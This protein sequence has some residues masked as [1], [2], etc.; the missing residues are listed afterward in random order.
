MKKDRTWDIT[1]L[2]LSVIMLLLMMCIRSGRFVSSDTY[3]H[4]NRLL[5]MLDCFKDGKYPWFYYNDFQGVG[6]STPFFYGQ[7]TLLPFSIFLPLGVIGF[8]YAYSFICYI[9]IWLGVQ[10]FTKR[11]SDKYAQIAFV[12]ILSQFAVER[13]F[14]NQSLQAFKIGFGIG[15]F[16]L[17]YCVDIFRDRK[18]FIKPALLFCLIFDTSLNAAVVMFIACCVL[19]IVYF[20]SRMIRQYFRFAVLC[21]LLCSYFIVNILYHSDVL[22]RTKNIA[23]AIAT[24]NYSDDLIVGFSGFGQPGIRLLGVLPFLWS[25]KCLLS[26]KL[27]KREV[28]GL[29][30]CAVCVIASY[31]PIFI[32]SGLYILF[33]VPVR[34]LGIIVLVYLIIAFRHEDLRWF[35]VMSCI[36]TAVTSCIYVSRSGLLEEEDI[37]TLGSVAMG[38]YLHESFDWEVFDSM[39]QANGKAFTE[40]RG[41][42]VMQSDGEEELY[43][44]KLYYRGY[45]ASGSDRT[46]D[47][48]MG[49]SQFIY[50]EPD[51]YVGEIR[52]EYCHPIWLKTLGIFCLGLW[53]IIAGVSYHNRGY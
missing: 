22:T 18:G 8:G 20:D 51:G 4:Y 25:V 29:I 38:D 47:V 26:R 42:V 13:I 48:K 37:P 3:F 6:Y 53:L 28:I 50:V 36:V 23:F 10:S 33:Q 34:Y 14:Y 43:F 24:H 39:R 40:S 5:Q 7:L 16:F 31:E 1:F 17:A 32:Y 45:R 27:S 19:F 15:F 30:L 35:I 41:I 49:I 46:F 2:M 12:F 21:C 9:V 44:P 52:L 11:F